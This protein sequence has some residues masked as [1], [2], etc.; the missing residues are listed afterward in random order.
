MRGRRCPS[1]TGAVEHFAKPIASPTNSMP[2]TPLSRNTRLGHPRQDHALSRIRQS[3]F[4]GNCGECV[5]ARFRKQP[6]AQV[7]LVVRNGCTI[8]RNLAGRVSYLVKTGVIYWGLDAECI[9]VVVNHRASE[10][11]SKPTYL[12]VQVIGFYDE[13]PSTSIILRRN[14]VFTRDGKALPAYDDRLFSTDQIDHDSWDSLHGNGT[15]AA[16]DDKVGTWHGTPQDGVRSSWDDR[17]WFR[18]GRAYDSQI[19]LQ[20]RA[21]ARPIRES[22]VFW[23]D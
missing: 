13:R 9:R 14:G 18:R 7:G 2:V 11:T 22:G 6:A 5:C 12:G 4:A 21:L 8:D 1:D 3:S 20:N 16:V 15:L 10:D 19:S 23:P 17:Y